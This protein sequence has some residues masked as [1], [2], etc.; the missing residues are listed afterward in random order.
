MT[1][2]SKLGEAARTV[3]AAVTGTDTPD[4]VKT[5]RPST[6]AMTALACIGA[7]MILVDVFAVVALTWFFPKSTA[8]VETTCANWVG[9][10]A[11]LNALSPAIVVFAFATP[12][13]GQVT[14]EAGSAK[15]VMGAREA[16]S[17][18]PP[19]PEGD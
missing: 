17:R 1:D 7:A 5:A 6:H 2:T 19:P 13:V 12:W 14:A 8:S 9:W 10:V 18:A 16:V 11:V 15:I 3:A 4:N